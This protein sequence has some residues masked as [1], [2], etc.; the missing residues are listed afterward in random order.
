[1]DLEAKCQ[2][3]S[4]TQVVACL[5]QI[6]LRENRREHGGHSQGMYYQ[7]SSAVG[8]QGSTWASG[9]P[10]L[11]NSALVGPTWGQDGLW[12]IG[13]LSP[14]AQDW[15]P[16]VKAGPHILP[17]KLEVLLSSARSVSNASESPAWEAEPRQPTQVAVWHGAGTEPWEVGGTCL[18]RKTENCCYYDN[19]LGISYCWLIYWS[20]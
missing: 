16:H 1:M 6:S 3:A 13:S 5:R 7:L 2:G 11:V 10:F 20:N 4:C 12:R 15:W 8:A 17:L 18:E 19:S 14:S 9:A